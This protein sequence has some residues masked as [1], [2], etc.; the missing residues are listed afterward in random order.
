VSNIGQPQHFVTIVPYLPLYSPATAE[1]INSPTVL[2]RAIT[3]STCHH[4]IELVKT[5]CTTVTRISDI[6][7]LAFVFLAENV[8]DFT[9]HLHGIQN[10]F[11]V[12]YKYSHAAKSLIWLTMESFHC[13]PDQHSSQREFW[14]ECYG[15]SIYTSIDHLRQEFW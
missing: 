13:F 9:Y 3:H 5:S 4:V 12:R 14:C 7:R 1:Y 15:R 6:T 2:P 8:S 10:A 11:V